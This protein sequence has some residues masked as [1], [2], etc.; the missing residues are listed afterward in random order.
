LGVSQNAVGRCCI[1]FVCLIFKFER[2]TVSL[3]AS[4]FQGVRLCVGRLFSNFYV[5]HGCDF[6]FCFP[7]WF[8][9]VVRL[10]VRRKCNVFLLNVFVFGLFS[11][12][13]CVTFSG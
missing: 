3:L 13:M 5:V 2:K 7:V 9:S 8:S 1:I 12:C 10:V 6:P 4:R 11:V